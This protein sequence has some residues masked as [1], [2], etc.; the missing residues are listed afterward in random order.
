MLRGLRKLAV[1]AA[2]YAFAVRHQ[3]R[4]GLDRSDPGVLVRSAGQR[5]PVV[6]LPG[7]YE[8]WRFL[9]PLARHLHERGHPV[10][11]VNTL[12]WNVSTIAEGSVRVAAYLEHA[13]LDR[14]AI[15]AHS[16][17]GLIAKHLMETPGVG[18]KVVRAITV[19]TPFAGSTLARFVPLPTVRALGPSGAEVLELARRTS[20]NARIVAVSPDF[21]PHIPGGSHLDGATNIRLG[22]SGHFRILGSR[23]L[24]DVLDEYLD[25]M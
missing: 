5:I 21:D 18:Q 8:T 13:D 11:I 15:V 10:H 23:E 19:A 17:G 7:V 16:K 24:F 4:A 25:E 9:L 1:V 6:L 2:D 3:L 12:R 14:V 20:A 22:I